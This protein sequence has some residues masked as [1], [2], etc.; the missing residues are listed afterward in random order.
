MGKG[1]D[2]VLRTTESERRQGRSTG[3]GMRAE[4]NR[5]RSYLATHLGLPLYSVMSS[6]KYRMRVL[7]C[8]ANW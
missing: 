2:S 6:Y 3:R 8:E 5:K 4:V 7:G 1:S